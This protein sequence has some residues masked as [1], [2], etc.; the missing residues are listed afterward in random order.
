LR[1]CLI[2]R[3]SFIGTVLKEWRRWNSQKLHDIVNEYQQYQSAGIDNVIA[4]DEYGTEE[5]PEAKGEGELV[6][7]P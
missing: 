1:L 6:A 3:R 7:E 2:A 5:K 4:R